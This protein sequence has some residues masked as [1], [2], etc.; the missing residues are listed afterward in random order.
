VPAPALASGPPSPSASA[1][2]AQQIPSGFRQEP[3]ADRSAQSLYLLLV[4]A[5]V[6]TVG[7]AQV[8]RLLG[9]RVRFQ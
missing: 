1:A 6:A 9:I 4:L 7:G 5:A 8:I 3:L 2:P